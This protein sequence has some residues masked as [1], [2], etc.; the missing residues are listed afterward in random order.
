MHIGHTVTLR[1]NIGDYFVNP[2]G[3]EKMFLENRQKIEGWLE[4]MFR[5]YCLTPLAWRSMVLWLRLVRIKA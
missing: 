1:N 3:W 2:S 4:G 5:S